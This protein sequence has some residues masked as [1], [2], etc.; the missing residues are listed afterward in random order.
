MSF[1]GASAWR[2]AL[3]THTASFGALAA[4][5]GLI[6]RSLQLEQ[7]QGLVFLLWLAYGAAAQASLGLA[8]A[9]VLWLRGRRGQ[10]PPWA[11]SAVVIPGFGYLLVYTAARIVGANVAGSVTL[12]PL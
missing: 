2:P 3:L 1:D 5:T 4:I 6:D 8:A 9:L 7:F 12:A 11:V 10:A